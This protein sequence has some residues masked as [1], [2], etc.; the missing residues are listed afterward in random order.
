MSS[1]FLMDYAMENLEARDEIIPRPNDVK[2]IEKD[3]YCAFLYIVGRT[4]IYNTWTL[5]EHQQNNI[6]TPFTPFKEYCK[7]KINV[8]FEKFNSR[9]QQE[10]ELLDKVITFL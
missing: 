8:T 6:E 7:P 3:K 9:V 5:Q 2:N 1:G 4:E 10:N